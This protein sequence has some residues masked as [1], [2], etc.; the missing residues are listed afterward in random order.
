MTTLLLIQEGRVVDPTTG[1]DS[2][3]DVLIVDGKIAQVAEKIK[4]PEQCYI[5]DASGKIVMPGL[6]D[7][8]AHLREPGFEYKEDIESGTKAAAMGGFSAVACMPNTFPACD[9]D[10]VVNMIIKRAKET[11]KVKVYPIGAVTKAR[12]GKELAEFGEM[13]KAGAVAFSDD[14][15]PV[16][17]AEILRCAL[18]YLKAF[19]TILIDH[20]EDTTLSKGGQM[21]LGKNSTIAGLPGIPS[22]SEEIAVARDILIAKLTGSPIH[23]AHISTAGSISMIRQAKAAGIKVTC[24][25]TP[26]HLILTDDLV[27]R[28]GYDTNAK[29]SPPLRTLSDLEALKDALIDGTVDV[30]ATDHAPH[31]RDDKW[32]EYDYAENGM[33][34]LETAVSLIVDRFVRTGVISWARMAELMSVKPASILGVPGGTLKIGAP[35]DVT[36]ID[37]GYEFA[38]DGN[39]FMSKSKNSPFIGWRLTGAPCATVVD[40]KLVMKDRSLLNE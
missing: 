4:P 7:M 18:E 36:V 33:V 27:I 15:S 14:G 22:E 21:N 17:T 26:H 25:V 1:A 12:E 24:E 29:V 8:H 13:I 19:N 5:L 34:G 11:G 10:S 23:L 6:I 30:I 32:V 20:P 35:G 37:P 39:R 2:V 9:N 3:L 31:H 28:S 16:S 40:G 38:V